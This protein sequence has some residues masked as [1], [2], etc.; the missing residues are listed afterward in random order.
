M[1]KKQRNEPG[2]KRIAESIQYILDAFENKDFLRGSGQYIKVNDSFVAPK[3]QDVIY[4]QTDK[5]HAESMIQDQINYLDQNVNSKVPN[6]VDGIF[7]VVPISSVVALPPNY[8]SNRI[9]LNTASKY[10]EWFFV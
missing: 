10:S 7:F 9:I 2:S 8:H 4:A 6:T 1:N 3:Y 5:I